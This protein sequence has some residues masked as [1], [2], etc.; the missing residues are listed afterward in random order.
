[1]HVY[2]LLHA[3]PHLHLYICLY[4]FFLDSFESL[5]QN[6][7]SSSANW[8]CRGLAQGLESYVSG[9]DS[10]IKQIAIE[11]GHAQLFLACL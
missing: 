5:A 11:N 4:V 3:Y 7:G 6:R 1:M 8:S 10:S 2:C 9:R